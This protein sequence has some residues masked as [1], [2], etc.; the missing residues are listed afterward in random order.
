MNKGGKCLDIQLDKI[1][2][3]PLK[4]TFCWAIAT[5]MTLWKPTHRQI[6]RD[7]RNLNIRTI[8][9][10]HGQYGMLSSMQGILHELPGM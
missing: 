8:Q 6:E 2:H 7:F 5:K 9:S 10:V 4:P 3:K 1:P